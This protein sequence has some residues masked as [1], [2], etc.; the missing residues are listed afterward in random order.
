MP[1]PYLSKSGPLCSP[2]KL[3]FGSHSYTWGS[4]QGT[5]DQPQVLHKPLPI[6]KRHSAP[7]IP[8]SGY[9]STVTP[10]K[11][12]TVA[13]ASV[14]ALLVSNFETKLH[15]PPAPSPIKPPSAPTKDR[16]FSATFCTISC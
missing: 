8:Q 9:P 7:T 11:P 16:E 5:H 1:V 4:S 10:Q 6:V 14:E 3:P 15:V 13:S 12:I 2:D